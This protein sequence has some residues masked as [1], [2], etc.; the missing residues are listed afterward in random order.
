MTQKT[1]QKLTNVGKI[2]IFLIPIFLVPTARGRIERSAPLQITS[3][4][5]KRDE[6][7]LPDQPSGRYGPRRLALEF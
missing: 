7:I 6:R 3:D 2:P 4:E 1:V 5:A